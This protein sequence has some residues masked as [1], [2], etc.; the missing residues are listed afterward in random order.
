MNALDK[1]TLIGRFL[2]HP[3]LQPL[4]Q[5]STGLQPVHWQM[6]GMAG[7]SLALMVAAAYL[8]SGSD[9]WI[10]LPDQEAAAYAFNDLESLFDEGEKDLNKKR[11]LYFPASY[12]RHYS[13][14]QRDND[15]I[16]QRTEVMNRI[17]AR[18]N[19]SIILTYP[20]AICEKVLSHSDIRDKMLSLRSGDAVDLDFVAD[21][22]I[23][24]AFERVDFVVE[25]GQFALRGGIIDV[26]SFANEYPFRIEFAGNRIESLRTF[27]PQDQ[28]SRDRLAHITLLPDVEK[29]DQGYQKVSLGQVLEPGSIWWLYGKEFIRE[30]M[31]ATY[32]NVCAILAEGEH[33]DARCQD[34]VGGNAFLEELTHFPLIEFA[35]SGHSAHILSLQQK[36]QP[37]FNKNFNLLLDQLRKNKEEGLS[38]LIFTGNP[39]QAERIYAIME[40][41]GAG[42]EEDLFSII[43]F[44][45][46]EGFTDP[47]IGL[48]C[49]TDHQIFDRYHRFRLRDS[50]KS[51]EAL[52]IKE[53]SNL[54]PG[55]YV[56]HIDH[57]VGRFDGLEKIENNGRMQEAIRMVYKNG[58]LLYVSIHSLH[59]IT[60][61]VGKEGTEPGLDKLGSGAWAKLKNKTK[62]KVQDIAKDLIKLYAQRKASEG[63]AFSPDSYLQHELEA[64]FI[65]ED[66][67]DQIKATADVKNDLEASWPM[68][69][70]VCGDVGFGKTE[71]ALRAAFKVVTDSKQVAVLVPTTILAL[72]HYKTFAERL[73][74]FP[75]TVDYIN[76]FKSTAKQK[77]TLAKLAEGKIDILIGTHRLLSKDVKFKDL[78][79]LIIDEEQRFG[80]GAKEKLKEM[81]VNVDSL[82]L[83]ATPIPRT[84]QFSLMGARDLSVINTPPPNRQP[85]HTELRAF[86]EEVIR[87]AVQYEISRGGQVFFVHNRIQN[88]EDVAAM[89]RKFV[90]GISVMAAHGQMDGALLEQ[91]ML[92]FIEG[93]YDVLVSTTIIE[94][95]LDISNANTIII[96]DAQNYG[97][98]DLHQLRGR[99]GRSNRK[100]FCYL[101][102]PPL[103]VI[104][105]EGRK[106]LRAIEEFSG[107]GSGFSIAMRDL[108][109]RGAGNILGAEQSGFISEIG[110]EMYQKILDEA[111]A[112]LRQGEFKEYFKD[113]ED[114]DFVRDCVIETDLELMIPDQ[115]VSQ[116]AERL[117]LYKKLDSVTDEAGLAAFRKE[118]H[119]RF[120]PLP[121]ATASLILSIRMRWQ[122]GKLGIEKLLLKNGRMIAYFI[123]DQEASFYQSEEFQQL[124]SFVQRYP[125]RCAMKEK[126]G[127]L[128]LTFRDVTDVKT[129]L[130]VLEEV[131][132][133]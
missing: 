63:Y 44:A 46:H 29:Q 91:I 116:I 65:Y 132:G 73:E 133:K 8:R 17:G 30:R 69:R 79:L 48:A 53:L 120:G 27:N 36:P 24:Y 104:S 113:E 70:L 118:M 102:T 95:G 117:S 13:P 7:S 18:G 76:R 93:Q 55:D 11:V 28:L 43:H 121:E 82:T 56:T 78:G 12:R 25:P 90:P 83:T 54:Q 112:E 34:Y 110:Y 14:G 50:Y 72:Q 85:V 49:Y 123:Q 15:H 96:N 127:R 45:L 37:S 4:F 88:I 84:L 74:A 21:V 111:M 5:P 99:V 3:V 40:D 106:R 108:D 119:D 122:A 100:A 125:R 20:E 51:K 26:F 114:Q 60:K 131:A 64:S 81:R 98:S 67:P 9:H 124:L 31:N 10:V 66:T 61:Y 32:D 89:I 39:R 58:D 47:D 42:E 57:G 94:S 105:T 22:L 62:K 68:D 92:D 59:R 71:V 130:E 126:D 16:L 97:L 2:E 77:E 6:R 35:S 75:V 101:L 1:K 107:L 103:S 115:Y 129:A 33:K 87:D 41:I 109:I 86:G 19:R 128:S 80:V 23:D 38:N 52:T